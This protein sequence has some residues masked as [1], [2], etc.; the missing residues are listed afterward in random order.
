MARHPAPLPPATPAVILAREAAAAGVPRQ[1]LLRADMTRVGHGLYRHDAVPGTAWAALGL[2]EPAH[3]HSVDVLRALLRR[4]PEAVLSHETAAHLHGMP[5]P[6][7]PWLR[8]DRDGALPSTV[9]PVHLT[10]PRGTRRIRRD[11]IMDHRRPLP[12]EH[13][14]VLHGLRVTTLERTWLDLCSLGSP[15]QLEDLVAAGD[16]CLKRPWTPAGRLPPLATPDSLQRTLQQMGRFVGRSA[17]REA[18]ELVRVGADS[19]TETQVRLSLIEAGLP[20]PELQ[21]VIDPSDPRSPEADLGYR[22]LRLAIQ[23][24]GVTHLT[25][26]QQARDARRERYCQERAWLAVRVTHDDRR[27]GFAGLIALVRRRRREF[28]QG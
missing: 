26:E 22:S 18:I 10:L 11:G 12:A 28:G 1:R 14:T 27:E 23:Y 13:V 21:L 4:R 24:D 9:P 19:P 17:A 6:W 20:E 15:W 2:A 25:P 3:G 5:L 16:H 7:R 8:A